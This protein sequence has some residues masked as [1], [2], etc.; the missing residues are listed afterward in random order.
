MKKLFENPVVEILT[1]T[2]ILTTSDGEQIISDD[3][4]AHVP[5]TGD[6]VTP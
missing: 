6:L 2:D 3:D 5:G 1:V 4:I